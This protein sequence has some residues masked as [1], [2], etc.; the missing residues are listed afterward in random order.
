MDNPA[1]MNEPFITYTQNQAA[2]SY[3]M[4]TP[5]LR[6]SRDFKSKKAMTSWYISSPVI[7]CDEDKA[8]TD[9]FHFEAKPKFSHNL[10]NT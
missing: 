3:D 10:P 7:L 1:I 2:V 4:V 8:L 9:S 5:I 6:R